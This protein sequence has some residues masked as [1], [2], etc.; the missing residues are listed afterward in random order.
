MHTTNCKNKKSP[1]DGDDDPRIDTELTPLQSRVVRALA[2]W[3]P[4]RFETLVETTEPC[5][6]SALSQA[7]DA[8]QEQQLV[9]QSTAHKW[10]RYRL[11]ETGQVI[12]RREAQRWV[13]A[14][15]AVTEAER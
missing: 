2:R 1:T 15:E 12:V 14:A 9:Q 13:G 5:V 3:G 7:L 4:C 10:P 8:L 6:E 11:S